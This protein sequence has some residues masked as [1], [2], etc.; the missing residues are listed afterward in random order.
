MATILIVDDDRNISKALNLRLEA[1]GFD[2]IVAHDARRALARVKTAWPDLA[3]LDISMPGGTGFDLAE[4][5]R[6]SKRGQRL[7]I[8]FIT[9]SKLHSLRGRAEALGA[10]A[11]IEKPYDPVYL[12]ETIHK[13][14]DAE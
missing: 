13:S 11:F 5:L 7:P 1:A 9:A 10:A 4:K 14:L 6:E 3:L 8:I 2:V 12:V